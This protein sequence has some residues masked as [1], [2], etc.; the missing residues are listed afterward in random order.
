LRLA[1]ILAGPTM[2]VQHPL[3]RG[4]PQGCLVAPLKDLTQAGLAKAGASVPRARRRMI[5]GHPARCAQRLAVPA[6]SGCDPIHRCADGHGFG[7]DPS[8]RLTV[9]FLV[10]ILM[11]AGS[12]WD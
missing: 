8:L 9:R 4:R 10:F 2:I 7:R 1:R 11:L 3:A 12:V 5:S 6:Y